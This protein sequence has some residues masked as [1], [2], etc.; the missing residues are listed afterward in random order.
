MISEKSGSGTYRHRENLHVS[1]QTGQ[2]RDRELALIEFCNF[3]EFVFVETEIQTSKFSAIREGVTDF[4]IT[5]RR[6]PDASG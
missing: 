3:A 2:D 6:Y 5:T 1:R 4:G